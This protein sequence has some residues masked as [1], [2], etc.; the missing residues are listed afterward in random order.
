MVIKCSRVSTEY[1]TDKRAGGCD[2]IVR[3]VKTLLPDTCPVLKIA[4]KYV[5]GP[6]LWLAPL[7]VLQQLDRRGCIAAEMERGRREGQPD[8]ETWEGNGWKGRGAGG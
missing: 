5:C 8:S 4:S 6:G 2:G 7:I 1:R 3:A